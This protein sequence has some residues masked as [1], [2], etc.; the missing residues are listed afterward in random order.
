MIANDERNLNVFDSGRVTKDPPKKGVKGSVRGISET[1]SPGEKENNSAGSTRRRTEAFFSF[2][3]TRGLRCC[4]RPF[5]RCGRRGLLS[6]CGARTAHRCG[7]SCCQARTPGLQYL[8]PTGLAP[9]SLWN[10]PSPGMEPRS[11]ALASGFLTAGPP[12]KS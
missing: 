2:P 8:W 5:S 1:Q 7:F 9:D 12:R 6:S 4:A 11:P 3:A 10:L